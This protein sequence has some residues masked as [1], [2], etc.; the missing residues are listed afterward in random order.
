M[1]NV[2]VIP[3]QPVVDTRYTQDVV[4][5]LDTSKFEHMYRI[6]TA[7]AETSMVPESL[8]KTGDV[9]LPHKTVVANCFRVVNQAVR[10]GFDPF[11]VL[12][13]AYIVH[14]KLGWEGKLVA[15]VIDVKLGISLQYTFDDKPEQELGVTVS[16]TLPGES[17]PRTITG[18]V[19]DWHKGPKSPWANPDRKSVV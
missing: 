5:I 14:G 6:A 8:R 16:G 3:T 11:A 19:K 12:D 13:C 17:Q 10:W 18:R 2:A 9:D 7:M 15:A 4:P 1:S